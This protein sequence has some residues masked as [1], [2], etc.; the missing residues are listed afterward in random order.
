MESYF[1]NVF[2]FYL[3][4][5]QS[6]CYQPAQFTHPRTGRLLLLVSRVSVRNEKDGG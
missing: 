4:Y 3:A 6:L 2:L 1:G 5:Y